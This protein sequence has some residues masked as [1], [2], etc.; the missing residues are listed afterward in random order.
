MALLDADEQ[1]SLEATRSGSVSDFETL[2]R[3]HW[4]RAFRV[5]Y[6][7]VL[8][9]AAAEEIVLESFLGAVRSLDSYG[10][11][12]QFA[13]SLHRL[14]VNRSIDR[15]RARILQPSGLGGNSGELTEALEWAVPLGGP[16]LDPA[17]R[18]LAGGLWSLSPDLRAVVVLSELLDYSPAEMATV[19]DI[20]KEIAEFRLDQARQTLRSQ[21]NGVAT[22]DQKT[23]R[24]LLLQQPVPGE[25]LAIERTWEVVRTAF[26]RR[27]PAAGPRR[28]RLPIGFALVV[29]ALVGIGVAVWLTPAGAWIADSFRNERDSEQNPGLVQPGSP[30][31]ALPAPGR[32]LVADADAIEVVG[33]DGS[34][35]RIG[36]YAGGAWSPSGRFV[37]VWRKATLV[38]LDVA[39]PG[40]PLW[41][42]AGKGIA[43]ARWSEDGFRVAY[44]ARR[45]L[46]VVDGSGNEGRLVA[47]GV[48]PV[49]PAWRPGEGYVLAYASRDGRVRVVDA[50]TRKL[51]WQIPA[52]EVVGLAWSS[53]GSRLAVLEEGSLTIFQDP[54][55]VLDTVRFPDGVTATAL[56]ARPGADPDVAYVVLSPE[57]GRSS[58]F[59]FDA[60]RRSSELVFAGDGRISRLVWSPDG[61]YLLI[62]W[63]E[64]DQ[65]IFVPAGAGELETRSDLRAT[66]GEGFPRPEGWCCT[67]SE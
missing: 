33:E 24:T 12:R 26:L 61:R 59:L 64:G 39:Q 23:L 46:R 27:D 49:A 31:T 19:L 28:R 45:G 10:P 54:R 14:V 52:S 6:L 21:L 34:R 41:R 37:A 4:P 67:A 57:L 55:Q 30:S 38:G 63:R 40:L 65:W 18:A 15:A 42:V 11:E 1:A 16:H 53:D 58:V 36:E 32:L 9:H 13:P 48:A 17:A 60:G 56:A 66:G 47:R 2:F 5:S 22:L 35:T 44:R 50:D 62:P 8:D 25:H 51:Q 43:D 29:V 3:A 7:I 20:P